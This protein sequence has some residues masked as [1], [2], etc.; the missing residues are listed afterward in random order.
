MAVR[1]LTSELER[2]SDRS[3]PEPEITQREIDGVVV[4]VVER[5]EIP[6]ITPDANV[7]AKEHH[8]AAHIHAEV[9]IRGLGEELSCTVDPG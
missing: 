2:H 5:A 9:V 7:A 3:A 8:A 6:E 4:V 1:A